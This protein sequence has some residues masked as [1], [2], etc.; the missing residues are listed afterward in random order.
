MVARV[1]GH[2]ALSTTI[3]NYSYFD[4]EIAMR[5]YQRLVRDSMFGEQRDADPAAVAPAL[6][7][8]EG[9]RRDRS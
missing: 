6:E 7:F 1:L 4:G 9:K 8:P 2:R 3:R 5:A